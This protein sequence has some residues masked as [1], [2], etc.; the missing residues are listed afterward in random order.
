MK[1]LRDYIYE[2]QDDAP[3]RN[4]FNKAVKNAV[5]KAV[6][7]VAPDASKGD[8]EDAAQGASDAVADET[9]GVF[10]QNEIKTEEDFRKWAEAKFE[11]MFPDGVDTKKRDKVIDGL[12]KDNADA[13][14]KGDF[15]K[16]IGKLNK[17]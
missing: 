12:L 16:L 15:G 17:C 2:A 3:D 14:K 6:K 11:K 8:I 13:V 9:D 7:K 1:D 10:S 5:K 4:E